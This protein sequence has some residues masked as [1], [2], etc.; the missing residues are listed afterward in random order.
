MKRFEHTALV[1]GLAALWPALVGSIAFLAQVL[2]YRFT[3][4]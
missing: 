3:A 1:V 2:H 4:H